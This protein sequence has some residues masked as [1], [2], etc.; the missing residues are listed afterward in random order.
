MALPELTTERLIVRPLTAADGAAVAAATGQAEPG[1]LEWTV[2]G[3]H[4]LEQLHQPPYG[5]RAIAL[6]ATGELVGLIGVV[7]SMGPFRQLP[8]FAGV[9]DGA[10]RFR[11]EVGLFWALAPA[12]RGHGY[13]TEAATA[14]IERCFS[15][16]NLERIVATTMHDNLASI[17]VMRRLGMT[18]AANPLAEPPW[19]QVVGW[20]DAPAA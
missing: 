15:E 9:A 19:F 5:E 2:A 1:W 7:P 14:V 16:L 6:R 10:T 12:H 20:L 11:P 3:Y 4:Q 13:A 17:A 8:G 18:I